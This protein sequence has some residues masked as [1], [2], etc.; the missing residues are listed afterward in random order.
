MT[1]T[2]RQA[3]SAPPMSRVEWAIARYNW[4][5]ACGLLSDSLPQNTVTT[6]HERSPD[7]RP[8]QPHLK[9]YPLSKPDDDVATTY[10]PPAASAQ[11]HR[12]SQRIDAARYQTEI[13]EQAKGDDPR[14][15][16]RVDWAIARYKWYRACGLLADSP[17]PKPHL[18]WYPLSKPDRDISASNKILVRYQAEKGST[19]GS[20][21]DG[22]F[23]PSK[24]P[25]AKAGQRDG[26]RFVKAGEGTTE[27]ATEPF[28][29]HFTTPLRQHYVVSS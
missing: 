29:Q 21:S 16:S 14:T 27:A 15:W 5:R 8:P 10:Q 11:R 17:P 26:G 25:R 12:Y 6:A 23:D 18:K 19:K 1:S 4:Y 28:E 3:G 20:V 13:G 22:Q 7:P 2:K 24:H 9:W